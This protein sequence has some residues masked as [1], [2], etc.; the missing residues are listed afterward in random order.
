MFRK[1]V[2]MVWEVVFY[3][4]YH[5]VHHI[6]H[7]VFTIPTSLPGHGSCHFAHE[8]HMELKKVL[9]PHNNKQFSHKTHFRGS[10]IFKTNLRIKIYFRTV[11]A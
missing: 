7:M 2:V 10:N 6:Y 3:H 8:P 1:K 11:V 9:I 5:M 4:I